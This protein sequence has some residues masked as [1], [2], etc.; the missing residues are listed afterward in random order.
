MRLTNFSVTNFRSITAA[1]KIDISD[2]TVL[3]GKNNEGKSNLLKA[4]QVA[5]NL[6]QS[7]AFKESRR[8]R[9]GVRDHDEGYA[10]K[11]DFPIQHQER[12]T[13]KQTI[14]KLEFLLDQSEIEE[15]KGEIG[16][17]LMDLYH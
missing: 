8:L 3:I 5:M 14:F 10:W 13:A 16:S 12:K 1:H 15:F 2:T 17:N 4:L 9:V 11:R 7:H 6:L